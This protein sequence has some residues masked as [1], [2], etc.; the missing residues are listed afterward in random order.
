MTLYKEERGDMTNEDHVFLHD[1]TNKLSKID[2]YVT[3]LKMV[4]GET[5]DKL[6]KI[7]KANNEAVELVKS[8]RVY[9]EKVV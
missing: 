3:M 8:Y 4:I 6:L 5:D 2:G 7:E 9:L 1:L